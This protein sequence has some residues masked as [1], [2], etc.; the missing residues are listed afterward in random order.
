VLLPYPSLLT[1]QIRRGLDL[2]LRDSLVILDE[3]HNLPEAINAYNSFSDIS[4]SKIDQFISNLKNYLAK[5]LAKMNPKNSTKIQ[6]IVSFL[7]NFSLFCSQSTGSEFT[8][9]DLIKKFSS[10]G[11]FDFLELSAFSEEYRL[12]LKCAQNDF[13]LASIL[14]SLHLKHG[15][16]LKTLPENNISFLSFDPSEALDEILMNTKRIVFAGGTL[17]PEFGQIILPAGTEFLSKSFGHLIRPHQFKMLFLP[18]GVTRRALRFTFDNRTPE[19]FEELSRCIKNFEKIVP[20][21]IVVFFPSYQSLASYRT[22][23]PEFSRPCWFEEPRTMREE[24][25]EDNIFESYKKSIDSHQFSILFA[26]L[27]GRL[28]EGIN[29]SDNY[30]RAVVIVGIPYPN[31]NDRATMIK[32]AYLSKKLNLSSNDLLERLCLQLVNQAIGRA[33][34]HKDDYAVAI[35]LDERYHQKRNQLVFPHWMRP[36][37]DTKGPPL[38]YPKCHQEIVAFFKDPNLRRDPR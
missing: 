16:F 1:P 34:R 31:L 8:F 18:Q 4:I 30:A 23:R 35:L 21:G 12:T 2:S 19:I 7:T 15:T 36:F 20:G 28:S 26:V 14:S 37:I 24:A 13:P 10:L 6:Q 11:N 17:S 38:S 27:G 33:I 5:Y 29:F 9:I 25:P 22:S 32:T 3:A